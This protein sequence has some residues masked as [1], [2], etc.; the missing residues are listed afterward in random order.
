M[1]EDKVTIS[2]EE[3]KELL[4]IKGKYEELKSQ[5]RQ[6]IIWSGYNERGT[7]ILPCRDTGD[8]QTHVSSGDPIPAPPYKITCKNETS[9]GE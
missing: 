7:T 1:S 5:T 9:K 8:F 3:Y 4:I 6:P 2:M